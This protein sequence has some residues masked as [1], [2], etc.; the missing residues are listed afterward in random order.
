LLP[1]QVPFWQV[2]LWVQALLSLQRVPFPLIGFEQDPVL[3]LQVPAV[4]HWSSVLHTTG[5]LPV[6]APLTQVSV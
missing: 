5:L 6:Q 2:S 1:L 4:W 3:G